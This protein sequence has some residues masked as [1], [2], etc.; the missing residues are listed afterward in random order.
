MRVWENVVKI[1]VRRGISTF[2][3]QCRFML[4]RSEK[5]VIRRLVE[6]ISK[7]IWAY[8]WCL[9]TLKRPTIKSRG[10]SFRDVWRLEVC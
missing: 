6:N 7:E 9:L 4:G 10:K 1:K 3:I 8:I 5:E 2:K